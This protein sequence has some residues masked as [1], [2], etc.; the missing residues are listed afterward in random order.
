MFHPTF[1]CELVATLQQLSQSTEGQG[2]IRTSSREDATPTPKPG[3]DGKQQP[4]YLYPVPF[5][6]NGVRRPPWPEVLLRGRKFSSAGG[7]SPR[8]E[9][10]AG[11]AHRRQ[12][13]TLGDQFTSGSRP[14]LSL[15]EQTQ[16][17]AG[18]CSE[19]RCANS[20]PRS[21]RLCAVQ[22]TCVVG[23]TVRLCTRLSDVGTTETSPNHAFLR[24]CPGH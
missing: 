15:A 24:M 10:P 1:Q 13:L 14:S 3:K 23:R 18:F 16:W 9:V 19:T 21:G 2:T 12:R 4:T 8:A 17:P 7:S 22:P 6:P 5:Q 20:E 11:S